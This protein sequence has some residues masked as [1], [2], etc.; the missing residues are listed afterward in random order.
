MNI[1]FE[2]YRIFYVVAKYQ[3]IT[4]ASK[5]LMISQPAISKSIKNLEEQLGGQL[6]IRT[7][8]GV[9]LTE[10]GKEFFNY[11]E[12]AIEYIDNAENKFS[13][14]INLEVGTIRIGI[15]TT[16]TKNFLIPYLEHFHEKYPN[17]N[18]QIS[19]I[20]SSKLF[21][22]LKD[23]LLDL[24]IMNL[25][26]HHTDDI[27]IINVKT[28]HDCFIVGKAYKDLANKTLPLKE[29][30]SYPLILQTKGSTTRDYLDTFCLKNDVILNPIMNLSSYTLVIEFTK[31]GFG[32]GYATYEYIQEELKNDQLYVVNC[33]PNIKEK[34]IGLAYSKKNIPNFATKK[35]V[36]I[37]LNSTL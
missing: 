7:K 34:S 9:I 15:S 3:N 16:L 23:G 28:I 26:C 25:P 1:N 32:I 31:I 6:F 18:I 11:I 19:T 36:E 24:A 21:K 29:I 33:N 37:I 30:A 20:V 5:E 12:K 14:L 8:R 35:L 10:E 4:K 13:D 22:H 27:E 17:I 2:L